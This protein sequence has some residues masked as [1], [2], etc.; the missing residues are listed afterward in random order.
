MYCADIEGVGAVEPVASGRSGV[1]LT[2]STD[3]VTVLQSRSAAE[4]W[5]R[6][7]RFVAAEPSTA[8]LTYGELDSRARGIGSHLGAV[9]ARGEPVLIVYAPGLEYIAALF[10]CWYAGAIAVPAYPPRGDRLAARLHG[11]A[12]SSGARFALT[13]R[14]ELDPIERADGS[15]ALGNL[16]WVATDDLAAPDSQVMAALSPPGPDTI[17]LLQYTSGSTSAPKGVVLTHAH[18]IQNIEAIADRAEL[19]SDDR[20][21]SWLPPYHDMGLVTGILLPIV[22]GSEAT[23]MSPAAFLQRPHRWLQAITDFRATASAAPN[24]AYELCT[25]RITRQ[26]RSRLDLSA[27][28]TASVGAERIRPE[29]MER[30]AS[31]FAEVGF[32]K[33]SLK[34]C[35][36]LAEATLGVSLG[37]KGTSLLAEPIDARELA[38]GRVVPAQEGSP[39]VTVVGCGS[40]LGGADVR[41]VDPETRRPKDDGELG[42]VW[43]HTPSI[44]L[45]YWGRTTEEDDL[46]FRARIETGAPA[47]EPAMAYL[48]TGDLGFLR[49]GE[50]YITGRIKDLIILSGL[51]HHPEDIEATVESSH[52]APHVAGT[53]AFS[54]LEVDGEERLVIVHEVARDASTDLSDIAKTIRGAVA[55]GHELSLHD[56]VLVAPG[57][58]PKTSSGKVQRGLCRSL[59]QDG[60]LKVLATFPLVSTKGPAPSSELTDRLRALMTELLGV[61]DIQGDDDFF[62]LGGDSLI[63]T[64]LVS[65]VRERLGVEIPIRAVFDAR[66]A[67]GLSAVI[68]SLPVREAPAI[69]LERAHPEAK[70]AL[71]FSQERMWFLHLVDPRSAAYNVA[72]ATTIDGPL[73]VAALARALDAV[74][75]R[76]EVLRSSYVTVDG[77]PCVRVAPVV[78][79]QL[80]V[81]DLSADPAPES[82]A[83]ALASE[84]ASTP[85]DVARDVLLRVALYRIGVDRH[86]LATSMHHLVTDAWSMG[87]LLRESFA[88]YNAFVAGDAPPPSQTEFGYFDYAQWQRRTYARDRMGA[89]LEYWKQALAGAEPLE[90]PSDRPRAARR[91]T[92]GGFEPLAL[93][94]ELL[95]AVRE[96]GVRHGAT[97]FMVLLA[98]FDL[99]LHRY[100]GQSDITVGVPVANRNQLA[101]EDLVGTL[102]NTL[103]VRVQCEAE[104]SFAT[105]VDR[106]REASLAA[107]AHQ[108]VPF[109]RIVA[110]LPLERRPAESPLIQVMF[111][112]QNTPMPGGRAHGLSI[113]PL[114]VE[115][116]ASQFDLS[117]LVLDTDLGQMAGIEYSSE[118]FD[119]ATIRRL[120]GHFVTLLE[121]AVRDASTLVGAVALL[122]AP[123]RAELLAYA[124]RTFSVPSESLSVPARIGARA[125]E[126][127][128]AVAIEDEEG[129]LSY[130]ELWEQSAA[131]AARLRSLG[132]GPGAKVVVIVERSRRLPVALLAV[133]RSGAAYVPIDPRY[134]AA[135]IRFVLE[136]AAAPVV[137]TER[138]LR[139]LVPTDSPASVVLLGED[140]HSGPATLQ[141]F[142]VPTD[143]SQPAYVL[144]TSGS[145]GKPKGVVVGSGAL[146]NFLRSMEHTPGIAPHDRI[147]AVTTIAFDI[148]GLELWL[149]LVTG[150]SVHVARSDVLADGPRLRDLVERT[151]PTV[152]QA[153][154]ATWRLLIEA[155]WRGDPGMKLLCGGEAFPRDLADELL[156]RAGSVWNMYGPTETTIWST[157][158]RVTAGSGPVPIGLPIDRT[159]VYVLDARRALVPLGVPGEIYIGGDGVADGYLARPELTR[160]RFV[161]DPHAA[162]GGGRMYR[163]G[164]RGRLRGDFVLEHLGRLDHQIKLRG[165]RIE[166]GEIEAALVE[167]G[168][169]REA[170]VV[171]REERPGHPQLVAYCVAAAETAAAPRVEDLQPIRDTLRGR[172]P[173]YMVPAAFVMLAALP[174]TP[175]GKIDRAA[176]PAPHRGGAAE[177]RECLGPRDGLEAELVRV[178][179]ETLGAARL[180]VRDD[181][182]LLGGDSLMAVRL[183]A[184]VERELGAN[185]PLATLLENPTIEALAARIRAAPPPASSVRAAPL[186]HLVVVQP[187]NE[188]PPLVCVHGAGG[189]VL[190]M[191][192]IARHIGADRPFYGMQAR[193]VD[194]VSE[195]FTTIEEM[196]LAYVA[197]LR[198][199]QPRGPYYLSGYCGGGIVAFEMAR[200]FQQAGEDIASLVL[201]DT[202][203]PGSVPRAGRM[204]R[205][206][207]VADDG[208]DGFSKRATAWAGR[209]REDIRRR[210]RIAYHRLQREPVPHELRD[211][212][213]TWSFFRAAEQYRPR[214]FEGRLVVLRASEQDPLLTGA[215][216]DLGWSSLA[217]EG[218]EV[219]EIPG[220]H[221]TLAREPHVAVLASTL[222]SRFGARGESLPPARGDRLPTR[223]PTR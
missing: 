59:Y 77:A 148:A 210:A 40:P 74:V 17:A 151:R 5:R 134:P 223:L 212:W 111:D 39:A 6:A 33:S 141:S 125:A 143:L 88:F 83:A 170:V 113:R 114:A 51:N 121:S 87:V 72:G 174:R 22:L 48:R 127:P 43:V 56:V 96:M 30:F 106:V 173:A 126:T 185:V 155:G 108:D 187:G 53:V 156:P 172:L 129:A 89:D 160:E 149:P 20:V 75:A 186:E 4:P 55:S 176:L 175:N 35:Y 144:Y 81:M 32:R 118:L 163:T 136:D 47:N 64:Q 190:N 8:S 50:L 21:V 157:L 71:T 103:P 177:D 61:E 189:Q 57:S 206:A 73:D 154:P 164:D 178:W 128:A 131:L 31:A 201:I 80:T 199:R 58:V 168:L 94:P 150:A 195:P 14:A 101:S 109:E 15:R 67:A 204:E 215:P 41:I 194:G 11:I 122:Q 76:H 34:P 205:L 184:R 146:A 24:F 196:A 181:F 203:R 182:F 107:Y 44:G 98:A 153:T 37:A 85:F 23:L 70:L 116:G 79:P 84:L 12:A 117:L 78:R 152:M 137:V 197:D 95:R 220:N 120:L 46:V 69:R 86:V 104:I 97:P 159:R 18:F 142:A 191:T 216:A 100:T 68:E 221:E 112:Y 13:S 202:Y 54:L 25:R 133:L 9:G 92:A 29:T 119:R 82:R 171:V 162:D 124:E 179:V 135:R 218:V 19:T 27:W 52:P 198:V 10:G 217:T 207:R 139:A 214:L 45:G 213:L 166:P 102:V 1:S 99:L 145:T 219:L 91:S 42:E 123:E 66:T 2:V 209:H 49:G 115:R 165:F 62:A 110:S 130:R 63:A 60:R 167:S 147:L 3:L 7:F 132:A 28:R 200:L 90:L 222:R 169:A 36:G 16:H 65:R 193:G 140:A 38:S 93:T 105:L 188:G 192:A 211:F 138:H 183:L 180:G 26:Q 208:L 161:A 158:Q